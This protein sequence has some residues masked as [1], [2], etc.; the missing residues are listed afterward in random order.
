MF[1]RLVFHADHMVRL[2]VEL[3][4]PGSWRTSSDLRFN[5]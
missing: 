5:P 3:L 2:R 4:H 1:L